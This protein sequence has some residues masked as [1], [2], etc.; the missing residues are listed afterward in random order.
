[1]GVCNIIKKT[2]AVLDRISPVSILALRL[3]VAYV[4]WKSAI[5]KLPKGFLGVGEGNWDSTLFLFEHE[6]P[7]PGLS[8]EIAAYLGAGVEFLA[9][10]ALVIGLGSR[11]A[12]AALLAMTV[13][14][15]L[16]YQSSPDHLIWALFLGVIFL[17]GPGVISIDHLIRRKCGK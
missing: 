16:T 1:M 13:V 15:E 4:F 3:W 9:P 12:A 10:I 2:L 11:A 8:P 7:V 6:H 14:I 5:L 17:Q